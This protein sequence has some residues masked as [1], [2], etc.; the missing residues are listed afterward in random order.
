MTP[1]RVSTG[2]VRSRTDTVAVPEPVL[3]AWS[4]ALQ[5]TA[6]LPSAKVLPVAGVHVAPSVPS[7]RSVAVGW[8]DAG[9][10][11]G[12]VASTTTSG[13]VTVGAVVSRIVTVN[14]AA[15]FEPAGSVALQVTVV[16][17]IGNVLPVTGSHDGVTAAPWLSVADAT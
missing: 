10:P 6:E 9:A 3:P 8:S 13:T 1:V 12:P 16:T 14:V 5:V 17:P 4:V 15:L 11:A 7:T 2:G